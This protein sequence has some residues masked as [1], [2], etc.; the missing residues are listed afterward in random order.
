M[1]RLFDDIKIRCW[2]FMDSKYGMY[3]RELQLDR[4]PI[5]YECRRVIGSYKNKHMY[6]FMS[7]VNAE[8]CTALIGYRCLDFDILDS[9]IMSSGVFNN[10]TNHWSREDVN[11]FFNEIRKDRGEDEY[12]NILCSTIVEPLKTSTQYANS[13][14]IQDIITS[15]IL[16][17]KLDSKWIASINILDFDL[18]NIY[19]I[20]SKLYY[21]I[22][23]DGVHYTKYLREVLEQIKTTSISIKRSK[24]IKKYMADRKITVHLH[25]NL[26][27]ISER[28]GSRNGRTIF[29]PRYNLVR[30]GCFKGS[31]EEFYDKVDQT[32]PE[33]KGSIHRV[34]YFNFIKECK[35]INEPYVV[36]F[37]FSKKET[38]LIG[39]GCL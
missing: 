36:E 25:S 21:G 13:K 20:F 3:C 1:A 38:L 30:C 26:L 11:C 39:W 2:S 10:I 12:Y 23:E 4:T 31:L 19:E 35:R 29:S 8:I 17:E 6:K 5:G 27:K 15:L 7:S 14:S 24:E 9:S 32:Y 22:S 18:E 16:S 33:Y 37:L 34:N 28:I